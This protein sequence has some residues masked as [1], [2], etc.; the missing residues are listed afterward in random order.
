[1]YEIPSTGFLRLN[2][3]LEVIPIS[4]SSW[5]AGIKSGRYP[6]GRKLSERTTVWCVKDIRALIESV[7]QGAQK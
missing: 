3:V 1:M 7:N 6:A 4:K 2:Q 5:W